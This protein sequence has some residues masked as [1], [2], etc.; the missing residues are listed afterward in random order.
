MPSTSETAITRSVRLR[1]VSRSGQITFLI[2]AI[3]SRIKRRNPSKRSVFTTRCMKDFG[4][5]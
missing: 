4:T 3:V 2:S 1:V 5:S